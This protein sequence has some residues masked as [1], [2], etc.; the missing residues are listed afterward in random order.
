M[1]YSRFIFLEIRVTLFKKPLTWP[2]LKNLI[3]VMSSIH[4]DIE[5]WRR[6]YLPVRIRKKT[7]VSNY[8]CLSTVHCRFLPFA[9]IV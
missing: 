2:Q 3:V 5:S 8:K 1:V 4:L 9:P 7:V 6:L